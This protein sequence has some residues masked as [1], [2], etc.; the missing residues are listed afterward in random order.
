MKAIFVT[1]GNSGIGLALCR[2]LV[3]DHGC[4]VFMGSRSL[5]R[6]AA[7]LKSITDAHP[8]SAGSIEVVQIDV[9]DDDSV[10]AAAEVVKSKGVGLYA[11]V[12]N[13][14]V[15]L[16]ASGEVLPTNFYGPKRVSEAFL[17]TR[18]GP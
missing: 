11:I 18:F 4:R 10:A 1:G 13:A 17:E 7:G 5:E 2:Q 12:N 15:G 16:N 8:E 6:G 9:S 3:V 14:G